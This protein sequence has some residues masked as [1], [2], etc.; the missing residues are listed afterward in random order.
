[1]IRNIRWFIRNL[2]S[3]NRIRKMAMIS[4]ELYKRAKALKDNEELYKW[5]NCAHYD[6]QN[7]ID[8]DLW[9]LTK[10]F[11]DTNEEILMDINRTY[12]LCQLY[13]KG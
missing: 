9:F 12:R 3:W 6:V 7:M 8:C 5:A 4:I 10:R 2:V 11:L 13:G 1:M